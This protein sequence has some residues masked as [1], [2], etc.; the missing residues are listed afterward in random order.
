M[1]YQELLRI[2]REGS[3]TTSLIDEDN[4]IREALG[5]WESQEKLRHDLFEN[6]I[7]KK[8]P[9]DI[10]RMKHF[11]K[12]VIQVLEKYN[13]EIGDELYELYVK[14]GPLIIF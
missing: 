4:C 7:C 8:W 1:G 13:L 10:F 14:I 6:E 2:F 12:V 9:L 5:T 3:G 11:L